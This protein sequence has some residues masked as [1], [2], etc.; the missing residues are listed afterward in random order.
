[1][2]QNM[3][4]TERMIRFGTGAYLM[5][6]ALGRSRIVKK[7]LNMLGMFEMG[8]ALIGYC[9]MYDMMRINRLTH[10]IEE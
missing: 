7:P 8:T 4:M 2:R 1:M 5:G 9:P 10:S 6:T 3:D